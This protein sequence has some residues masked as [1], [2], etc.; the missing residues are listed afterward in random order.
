RSKKQLA[1]F[2]NPDNDPR[3]NWRA[4]DLSART[5]SASTYYPITLPSGK[6]VYPPASRSWIVSE[7]RFKDLVKDNR[8][9][10]GVDG[11]GRP[12]QKK[13]LTEIKDGITPQTWWDREFA[14]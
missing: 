2:Q 3:G 10:F 7:K 13:F 1:A 11:N 9:W 14:G 6:T 12:M 5:A 4:S 8:I